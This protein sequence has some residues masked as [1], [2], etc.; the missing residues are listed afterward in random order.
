MRIV[1]WNIQAGLGVDGR[2]DLERIATVI[3]AL[4]DAD[5]IC[6]QEV[7]CNVSAVG[8]GADQIT[9]LR[10]R[11]PGWS[12]HFGAAV[13][14]LSADAHP[15]APRARFGNVVLSRLPVLQCFRHPLPQPADPTTRHMPRQATEV[16]VGTGAGPLR[17]VTTHLEFHS[18]PQREAQVRHLLALQAELG[19][20]AA[21]PPTAPPDGLY[22]AVPRPS[23]SVLCG[24]FNLE[25]TS[26]AY[27]AL[28][29]DGATGPYRDAWTLAH[30]ALT[31]APTCGVHDRAQW[32][33]GPHCRD[34]F[35]CTEEIAPRVRE[36]VVNVETSASDH[37]PLLLVLDD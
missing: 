33:Q 34:F 37:Q 8:D 9:W 14:R 11:Y 31:H 24:D 15:A 29:G 4:G 22:A 10:H 20:A 2:H 7:A 25:T 1:S 26:R 35:L 18:E 23:A 21:H 13:D 5:V 6:L 27:R 30:P 28:T 17:I 16:I 36:L 3:A 32:P 19:E 12:V